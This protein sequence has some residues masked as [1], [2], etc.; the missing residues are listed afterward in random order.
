MPTS[1]RCA[2]RQDLYLPL[3]LPDSVLGTVRG[4]IGGRT[5]SS[6]GWALLLRNIRCNTRHGRRGS[7][8]GGGRGGRERRFG[9]GRS[10]HGNMGFVPRAL[11]GVDGFTSVVQ[12]EHRNGKDECKR[13][14]SQV[15]SS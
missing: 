6:T 9:R 3:Q 14:E 8:K 13:V 12:T 15:K 10:R 7:D 1:H 2:L 5:I 11:A 4:R